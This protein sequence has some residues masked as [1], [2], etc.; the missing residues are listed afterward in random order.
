MVGGIVAGRVVMGSTMTASA[1]ARSGGQMAGDL[2]CHIVVGPPRSGTTL[3]GYLLAGA[4]DALV[5]SEPFLGFDALP[6]WKLHRFYAR[7]Q[8]TGALAR[9]SP[10]YRRNRHEYGRFLKRLARASGRRRLIIKE[11]F[12]S[13]LDGLNWPGA[14]TMEEATGL[15]L[16]SA[17]LIRNPFDTVASTIRLA[18]HITGWRGR[19]ARLRWPQLPWFADARAVMRWAVHNWCA[20]G[21]WVANQ[22][23]EPIR[24]EDIVTASRSA[25]RRL[26]DELRIDFT[27]AMT[28]P[29]RPRESFG[30]L[31]DPAVLRSPPQRVH[32]SALGR[33]RELSLAQRAYIWARCGEL[34]MR[35][36]YRG[37][38]RPAADSAREGGH[39]V[40]QVG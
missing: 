10:P 35:W 11:T 29:S 16:R 39:C 17:Y 31:G 18:R 40:E 4:G 24:Y 36:G 15:W 13:H 33:G 32:Q 14:R 1:T 30:G 5:V 8:R 3:V 27:P 28:D 12:R 9:L 26:C 2:P 37:D 7:M 23:R 20:Y 21:E 34:A 38:S 6:M 22:S 25:V 19:L